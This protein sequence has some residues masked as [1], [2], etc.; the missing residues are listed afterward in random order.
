M[1]ELAG[2]L[3]LGI[4]AQ[5]LAWRIKVPAILPLII[6]GLLVGPFSTFLFEH[7]LIDSDD[8][9]KGDTLFDF[10]S[11]A[12]GVIL[13]E[14]GLSLKLKDLKGSA[15]T[16]L[17]LVIVG[18]IV[19]LVGATMAAYYIMGLEFKIALLFGSLV[20]VT[21]PTV[22]KP[23]LRNVR[24][25]HKLTT[26][27]NWEGVLI[28]PIGALVALLSYE[29]IVYFS[30]DSDV[31]TFA[32]KEILL[33]I[34][35]GIGIGVFMATIIYYLLKKELIPSYLRNV[36]V[37]ALVIMTVSISDL[38]VPESGLFA[39]TLAGI[40]LT[41]TNLRQI[42]FILSFKEDIT[43]ILISIL[44]IM[45]SS[46]ID[47]EDIYLLGYKSI[48]VFCIVVYVLRPLT[49][50]LSTFR[51]K[52]SLN[53]KLFLSWISPRGIVAAGVASIF[54]IRILASKSSFITEA[55]KQDAELVL[56]LTFLIII[57]TV[58]IQGA[59][60]KPIAKFLKVV[61]KRPNGIL[62]VGADQMTRMIA[63]YLK[64]M[65][66]PVLLSDT[67]S[68]NIKDAKALGLDTFEGSL[69]VDKAV[70]E[71]VDLSEYEQMWSMA[72]SA[73]INMLACRILRREYGERHVFRFISKREYDMRELSRP[74]NL[75]FNGEIDFYGLI[76]IMRKNPKFQSHNIQENNDWLFLLKE[77]SIIPL[78]Y[79]TK[80]R[81]VV[82]F[83]KQ[84]PEP[85]KGD[86]VIYIESTEM[87][88]LSDG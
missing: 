35:T 17:S 2:I 77:W 75:L 55:E 87:H 42:N 83:S 52:I 33:T 56:P 86:K 68:S 1:L 23:M 15:S 13:F 60:A 62:F 11:L 31:T 4:L 44:F 66:I 54:T 59:T 9:F 18:T 43:V 46:R 40:V 21:G 25:N 51:S 37:L 28:D 81:H 50:F 69:L 19:T 22:I 3:I 26:L 82:P 58:I 34:I 5:W 71:E 78:F 67:S 80:K 27:L 24:P 76:Q 20:I 84:S 12:V 36:V 63:F 41:N 38:I 48:I 32:V 85:K 16:V 64:R 65:G 47:M 88:L 49:I 74:K 8:I 6:I 30:K 29:F 70:T 14:G 57:G 39:V 61:H 7:K 45:L 79:I 10:L 73:E 53:E 72:S